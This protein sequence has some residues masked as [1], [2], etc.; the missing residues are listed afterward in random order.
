[1][2]IRCNL[3]F[4]IWKHFTQYEDLYKFLLSNKGCR[5]TDTLKK[6]LSKETSLW[7]EN[8][9][10]LC[11][12][13]SEVSEVRISDGSNPGAKGR[14][15]ILGTA[16]SNN[17]RKTE[18]IY[19]LKDGWELLQFPSSPRIASQMAAACRLRPA[20]WQTQFRLHPENTISK[21]LRRIP[22]IFCA[23]TET[24]HDY[25]IRQ[26]LSGLYTKYGDQPRRIQGNPLSAKDE[27]T[28][29][30]PPY[31]HSRIPLIRSANSNPDIH[32]RSYT[33]QRQSKQTTHTVTRKSSHK[34]NL[35]SHTYVCTV[36]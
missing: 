17:N 8:L 18:N 33:R 27:A 2:L 25:C 16:R 13:C 35:L 19:P 3:N 22:R 21:F 23:V 10:F 20:K 5:K 26:N 15:S 31:Q 28:I 34:R 1:M 6:I 32:R 14:R 24:S 9:L 30:P 11:H 12:L 36:Q 29:A 7:T 4:V